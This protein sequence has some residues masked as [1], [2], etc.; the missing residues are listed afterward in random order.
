[1]LHCVTFG[2]RL[3]KYSNTIT[4]H[5]YNAHYGLFYVFLEL[6]WSLRHYPSPHSAK[7]SHKNI[8]STFF[9]PAGNPP[10]LPA[11]RE[12]CSDTP[13]LLVCIT[14]INRYVATNAELTSNTC[15]KLQNQF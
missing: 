10:L 6:S 9:Q 12:S 5:D 14:S 13:L 3:Y 7:I 11:V 15:C 1:M 2:F 4:L 8:G